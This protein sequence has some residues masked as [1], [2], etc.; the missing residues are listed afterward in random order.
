MKPRRKDASRRDLSFERGP[1]VQKFINNESKNKKVD[2][3]EVV[4]SRR[5]RL[6][7][8]GGP[9]PGCKDH[10][11]VVTGPK[12]IFFLNFVEIDF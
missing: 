6:R 4:V 5:R 10:C 8:S 2:F 1:E 12:N 3:S 9:I 11:G 7:G